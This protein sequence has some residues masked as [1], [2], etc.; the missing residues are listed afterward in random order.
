MLEGNALAGMSPHS[1]V[2]EGATGYARGAP[3]SCKNHKNVMRVPIAFS[4]A[5][6]LKI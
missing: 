3:N 1:G 4:F 2:K 5:V 6:L